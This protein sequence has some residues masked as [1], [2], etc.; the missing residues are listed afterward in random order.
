MTLIRLD[1]SSSSAWCGV[2]HWLLH[3]VGVVRDYHSI[4]H[5]TARSIAPTGTIVY[6]TRLV[7]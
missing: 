6:S 5:A 4:F 2:G 7:E 1:P 3:P